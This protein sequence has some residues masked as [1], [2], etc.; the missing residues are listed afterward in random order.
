MIRQRFQLGLIHAAVA[1]TLVP[2]NSTLNR[3]MIKELAISATLV[4]ILASLPF[5]FSPIQVAIGSFSDRNPLFGW[6]R[7]PYIFFGFLLCVIGVLVLPRIAFMFAENFWA[8]LGLGLLAFGAWGM[9]YNFATVSYFSLASELSGEEER[10]KTISVMF[11]MMILSIILTSVTLSRLLD[12]Y[13]PEALIRSFQIIGGFA[14]V[15][16][17]IGM[18]KLE[19]RPAVGAAGDADH[20]SW[21]VITQMLTGNRQAMLFFL[22]LT[23]LLVAILGQDILL[24]PYGAEAFGLPVDA[25]T[26]ITSIWGV[27]FLIALAIGGALEGRTSKLVI[28]KIGAWCGVGAFGLIV[29]SGLLIDLPIFYTG[30]ILLGIAT[31]LSTVS[32]LSL[33]LDMTTAGSVGLFIGAWGMASAVARLIGNVLSGVIRDGITAIL[34]N[35]VAGYTIV[36]TL[37]MALLLVSLWLLRRVDVRLFKQ[38]AAPRHSIIERAALVGD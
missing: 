3:V 11:F 36:F 4:A 8:G 1:M 33:M 6:R 26:R 17:L 7:T 13:S 25:T 16:G 21:R 29:I 35:A 30:V 22:Y 19:K 38:E 24:E 32:N 31:G 18:I 14:L 2:I 34:E 37:E 23:L 20:Y 9:G 15:I 28:A 12:P 27:C 10:S 5:L